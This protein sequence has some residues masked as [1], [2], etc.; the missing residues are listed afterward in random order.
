MKIADLDNVADLLVY[1]GPDD[2]DKI[3]LIDK[4]RSLS[5]GALR[6]AVIQQTKAF[7][8]Q[9]IVA[10]DRVA[11]ITDKRVEIVAAFF[12]V[13]RMGAVLVPINPHL[14]REQIVHILS[15]SGARILLGTERRAPL[16]ADC[17]DGLALAAT[18]S[19][20]PGLA[21]VAGRLPPPRPPAS[22]FENAPL[23]TLFYTSG[24]TGLPKAVATSHSNILA[25]A[26]SVSGYLE[27]T[28]QDVILA[29]LPLS[30]D[31]GFSQ[32]TTGLG[33]GAT[34]VLRDYLL[35]A[36]I[37]RACDAHGVTGITGVP[38]IW[39]AALKASWTEAARA[40]VRYFANTG[41]HLSHERIEELVA[42]LPNARPFP[43]Y[44]L[45]E[46]FRSSYLPPE[47]VWEKKNSIGR[48]IPGATLVVVDE[49]GEECPPGQTGELIH[50]GPTVALGYWNNPEH[51]AERYRPAPPALVKRGFAGTVVYSG[52]MVRRDA[53]GFLY[54]EGRRDGQIKILGN[55]ISFT[56]IEDMALSHNDVRAAAAGGHKRALNLD[57][58]LVLFIETDGGDAVADAVLSE[59]KAKL[60]SYSV[61]NRVF[62]LRH[63]TVNANKKIDVQQMIS[64]HIQHHEG[65]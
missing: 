13:L 37:S 44:G 34:V 58:E 33:V 63:L 54:F 7:E 56:E 52:D 35:P 30:F 10:G 1:R 17:A 25:G 55:R 22:G 6:D 12:A 23:A 5:Y 51:T 41:G 20:E 39:G 31:A 65:V 9:G 27:N 2:A 47:L 28:A 16:L 59:L 8:N 48:A 53:D 49:L 57:P 46:A 29:I 15:D 64:E 43:M 21:E 50:A 62:A 60:P 11:V 38:A 19:E 32:L 3:A 18:V 40:K 45:T 42:L 14:K 26:E 4:K 36:D 61:P 24:S